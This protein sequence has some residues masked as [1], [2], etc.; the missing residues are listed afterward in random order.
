MYSFNL[1]ILGPLDAVNVLYFFATSTWLTATWDGPYTIDGVDILG[2]NITI[3]STSNGNILYT[4]FTQDTQYVV[5]INGDPCDKLRLTISGYNE[6]GNGVTT[7]FNSSIS[8]GKINN[9]IPTYNYL[10]YRYFWWY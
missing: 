7:S 3:A 5:T 6:A 8:G 10:Y 1:C 9:S 4:D 2:Y